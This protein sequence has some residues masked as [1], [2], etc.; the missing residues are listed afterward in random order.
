[1]VKAQLLNLDKGET[2]RRGI[3]RHPIGLIEIYG[4]AMILIGLCLLFL[5]FA[6]Q[7]KD[8]LGV[9][10][11]PNAQITLIIA[12]FIVLI[13]VV[14]LIAGRIYK[15][16]EL[17]LTNENI[18]QILQFGLFNRQISR[19]NLAKIQDVSVDQVGILANMMGYGT[20]DVETAGE[21]SNFRFKYTP[22][23]NVMAKTIIEAHEDYVKRYRRQPHQL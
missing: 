5:Y 23:P 10:G 21:Q 9:G 8:T 6:I 4:G 12:S 7:N 18:I 14:A 20:L 22:R 17:I 15:T 3:K 11:T 1:M 19:L 16:N 2:V 13:I